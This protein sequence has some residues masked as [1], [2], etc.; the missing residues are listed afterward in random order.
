MSHKV[1]AEVSRILDAA[2]REGRHAVAHTSRGRNALA[3]RRER[4]QL[5]SPWP[6]YYARATT[7]ESLERDAR[8]L[9]LLKTLTHANP[10]YVL[11]GPSAAIAH[12]L[13]VPNALRGPIHLATSAK[14]HTSHTTRIRRHIIE[15][16]ETAHPLGMAATSLER[17]VFDCLRACD[18]RL[19]LPIADSALRVPGASLDQ[20]RAYF[21]RMT[22]GYPGAGRARETLSRADPRSG[23]AGESTLRAA[24]AELGYRTPDLQVMV[25]DPLDP[26][27]PYEVDMGYL[28]AD[29]TWLFIEFDGMRKYG[30]DFQA[31]ARSACRERRRESRI[32]LL[33]Q[34]VLRLGW[35][36]LACD[37]ELTR[38]LD[39]FGAPRA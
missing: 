19:G 9:M 13:W 25:E 2:E 33:R 1:D 30:N 38:L 26:G 27:H 31:F 24:L 37:R 32:T 7:W 15:G 21:A 12:G 29:G 39:A 18:L 10:S 16:D 34:P 23:S 5:V 4:G 6:G 35:E 17:T 20:F 8:D 11:A 36:D 14:A 28:L 22:G 3:R